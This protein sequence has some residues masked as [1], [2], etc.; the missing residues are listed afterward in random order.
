MRVHANLLPW[1]EQIYLPLDPDTDSHYNNPART[2][3]MQTSRYP[4]SHPAKGFGLARE[5]L[6]A[7]IEKELRPPKRGSPAVGLG[8]HFPWVAVGRCWEDV[9]PPGLLSK[10]KTGRC[11]HGAGPPVQ[12]ACGRKSGYSH[13]I[14][15]S[16]DGWWSVLTTASPP[17]GS[18]V[19]PD[20]WPQINNMRLLCQL[21]PP[22][23]QLSSVGARLLPW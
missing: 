20:Q 1:G 8:Q 21:G 14:L 13:Y 3:W 16:G 19:C 22:P 10:P 23:W 12:G 18:L 2:G 17:A 4:Q 15:S 6:S 9:W 5:F 7:P 11:D